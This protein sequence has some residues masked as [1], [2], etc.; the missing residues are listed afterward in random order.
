MSDDF[1]LVEVPLERIG[2]YDP[3]RQPRIQFF[4]EVVEF[5][6]EHHAQWNHLPSEPMPSNPPGKGW[7][8]QV[9]FIAK[10]IAALFKLTYG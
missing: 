1:Y 3:V 7:R 10:D 8:V 9:R 2:R 5:L 6:W 4:P